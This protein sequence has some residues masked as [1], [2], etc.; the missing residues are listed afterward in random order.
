[1]PNGKETYSFYQGLAK[2]KAVGYK[3]RLKKMY[4]EQGK[5]NKNGKEK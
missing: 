2:L 1:M 3:D 5:A 4:K